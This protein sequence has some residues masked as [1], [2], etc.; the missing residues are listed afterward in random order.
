MNA[1]SNPS[2]YSTDSMRTVRGDTITADRYITRE[3]MDMEN[4]HLWPKIWHLGGVLAELE[5]P[6][7][8]VRHNFGKESVVMVDRRMARSRRS[9]I[10]A[11]IAATG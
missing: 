4:E 8:F 6:G 10:P 2:R 1:D 5:E 3:W 9:T 11:R 7:D